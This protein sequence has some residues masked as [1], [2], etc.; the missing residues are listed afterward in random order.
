MWTSVARGRDRGR[1]LALR[2]AAALPPRVARRLVRGRFEEVAADQ[3]LLLALVER[4]GW[5]ATETL[6]PQAARVRARREARV[7]AGPRL[8]ASAGR[9]LTVPG[10]HGLLEG[11]LHDGAGAGGALVV[12]LHGG[13]W[14]L[15]DVESNGRFCALLARES[16]ARVLALSYR[17]APESPFP[18]A[19]QDAE[20]ALRWALAHARDL[21]ARPDRVAVGGD[22]AGANLAAVA[23]LAL[24]EDGARPAAQALLY[25]V[26]DV[27]REHPSY[28]AFADGPGLTAPL[29][30]WFRAHYLPTPD[31]AE[32]PRASPLLEPD[33]IGAPLAYVGI[34]G[35]DPLRDEGLAFARRLGEAGVG[36][37]LEHF[38]AHLHAYAELTEVS[39]SARFASLRVARWLRERLASG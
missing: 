25:P 20:A 9:A 30:R 35:V 37:T 17:R 27:S 14:V 23:A 18:A 19:V 26:T 34:A 2:A 32:D 38:P 11:R 21:G 8:T 15:G 1:A 5:P 22:S 13:G 33:L 16:G 31:A 29:M 24:R 12:W 39:P 6:D 7:L 10:A 4:F 3:A 36:V 28:A